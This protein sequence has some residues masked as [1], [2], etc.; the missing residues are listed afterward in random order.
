MN[1]T[2][3]GCLV[4]AV[5]L[6]VAAIAALWFLV[7]KPAAVVA[8]RALDSA[9]EGIA[10]VAD[11]GRTVSRMRELEAGVRAASFTAPA[12]GRLLPS[13][14]E[15]FLTVQAVVVA[16][17]GPAVLSPDSVPTDAVGA[18]AEDAGALRALARL[19]DTGM[20]AKRAQVDALNAQ[21]MSLDEY[22]WIR[23]RATEALVA[24]G[25]S[26]A[27]AGASGAGSDALGRAADAARRMGEVAQRTSEATTAAAEAARRAAEAAQQAW[28]GALEEPAAPTAPAPPKE[29]AVPADPVASP[30]DPTAAAS[31][32]SA[33]PEPAA[34]SDP[35][36]ANFLLV[37]PHAEAF[38]RAQA[39]AALGL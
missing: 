19:G 17:L 16:A 36:R 3:G 30:A 11:L 4:A 28:R 21:S 39:M 33:P 1:K 23:A 18:V 37:E 14:V 29:S 10:E 20:A 5:V 2:L 22:R 6:L 9:R 15:D 27:I 32:D 31:A 26:V 7:L 8:D 25:V 24:G 13:Q 34:D 35:R 38:V 12:D